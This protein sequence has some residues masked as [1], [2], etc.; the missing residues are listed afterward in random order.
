MQQFGLTSMPPAGTQVVVIPIGG[1]TTHSVVVATENGNFRVKNLKGGG[2]GYLRSVW[3]N[4][5]LKA[6]EID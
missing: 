4:Y 1:A 3:L 2:G 5:H 6:G